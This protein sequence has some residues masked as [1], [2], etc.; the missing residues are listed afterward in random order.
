MVKEEKLR[1]KFLYKIGLYALKILPMLL[2]GIDLLHT[3]HSYYF[4][5]S[6]IFSYIGGIGIIVI[7]YLYINSYM[8]RF[9]EYHR[10]FLHYIV[11]NNILAYIDYKYTIPLS[12]RNLF[13]LYM[14]ITGITLFIIL[15][16]KLNS[17]VEKYDKHH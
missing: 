11:I 17:P 12:D 13:I 8:Y 7:V 14:I 5:D 15:Y 9:C 3:I 2:A 1:S 10:M 16:L 4:G 6:E